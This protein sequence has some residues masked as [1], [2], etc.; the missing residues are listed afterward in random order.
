MHDNKL[1]GLVRR[2][3]ENGKTRK[4]ASKNHTYIKGESNDTHHKDDS[5]RIGISK[6]RK[7]KTM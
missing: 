1:I 4:D 7:R 3:K 5:E 6:L 2:K